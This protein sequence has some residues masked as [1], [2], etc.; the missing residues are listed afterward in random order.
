MK[1]L[2]RV[3]EV[4]GT[5]AP[6]VARSLGGP[7]AGMATRVVADKLLGTP[8]APPDAIE[9]AILEAMPGD[10]AKLRDAEDQFRRDLDE[11]GVEVERIAAG[12]RASARDRQLQMKDWTPAVMGGVILVGFFGLVA[13]LMTTPLPPDSRDIVQILVGALAALMV[14]VANYFFGSS[15]GS[16]AKNGIIADLKGD[17]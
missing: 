11:A 12:D 4:L 8:D 15:A 5:V 16:A 7:L 9:R 2:T 13:L 10:L 1:H 14:Q 17:R 6:S 3:K